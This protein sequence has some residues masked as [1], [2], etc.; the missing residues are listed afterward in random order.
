MI[1]PDSLFSIP[2]LAKIKINNCNKLCGVW[3][4]AG[5]ATSTV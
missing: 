3:V 4:G 5:T 1:A 2:I